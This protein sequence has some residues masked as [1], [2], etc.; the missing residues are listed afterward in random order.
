M[1]MMRDL[2]GSVGPPPSF[3]PRLPSSD[4]K[5]N[6]SCYTGGT[7]HMESR[8]R[9]LA[10]TLSFERMLI[11]MI[12]AYIVRRDLGSF[13]L[14]VSEMCQVDIAG[15]DLTRRWARDRTGFRT[16]PQLNPTLFVYWAHFSSCLGPRLSSSGPSAPKQWVQLIKDLWT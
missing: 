6:L 15:T 11:R 4:A 16:F 9:I 10:L 3:L 14:M 1:K 8:F 7:Y 13:A 5:D 12:A 2:S